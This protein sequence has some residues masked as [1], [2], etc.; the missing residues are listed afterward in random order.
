MQL[1][2]PEGA[3][4]A[5]VLAEGVLLHVKGRTLPAQARH[6]ASLHRRHLLF[7]RHRVLLYVDPLLRQL[8]QKHAETNERSQRGGERGDGWTGGQVGGGGRR[9]E[10]QA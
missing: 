10:W 6:L 5:E 4:T 8:L 2:P 7:D 3:V 1:D 9:F